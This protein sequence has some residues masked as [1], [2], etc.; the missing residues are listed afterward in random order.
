[1]CIKVMNLRIVIMCSPILIG[2]FWRSLLLPPYRVKVN[3]VHVW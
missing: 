1:M 3:R 2:V